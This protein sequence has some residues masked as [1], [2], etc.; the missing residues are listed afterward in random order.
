[1]EIEQNISNREYTLPG[2]GPIMLDDMT[3]I[4]EVSGDHDD[5]MVQLQAS[6]KDFYGKIVRNDPNMAPLGDTEIDVLYE[7]LVL[8]IDEDE[9]L[10][11]EIAQ[12][13]NE[14]GGQ[15]AVDED[16]AESQ[17][18]EQNLG[19]ISSWNLSAYKA[20]EKDT[21]KTLYALSGALTKKAEFMPGVQVLFTPIAET[22]TI[23]W[24]GKIV[25]YNPEKDEYGVEVVEPGVG[26]EDLVGKVLPM[27]ADKVQRM[28]GA[29]PAAEITSDISYPRDDSG[30]GPDRETFDEWSQQL[31]D[32]AKTEKL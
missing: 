1:M 14:A 27:P 31:A 23:T 32:E 17:R 12:K 30:P 3:G 2:V 29:S 7:D 4:F 16:Q 18:M 13:Y 10:V 11:S 20:L 25:H 24:V 9:A 8:A 5:V 6:A 26:H 28:D 22:P 19:T 15:H 21:V